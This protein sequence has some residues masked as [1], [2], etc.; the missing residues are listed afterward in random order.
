MAPTPVTVTGGGNTAADFAVGAGPPAFGIDA[1]GRAPAGDP[2]QFMNLGAQALGLNPG[3]ALDLVLAGDGLDGSFGDAN[4][5]ILNSNITIRQGSVF[6]DQFG[7]LRM[8]IDV[9]TPVA[10]IQ[11]ASIVLVKDGVFDAAGFQA[12]I[13]PGSIA[14]VGGTFTDVTATADAIPL[15]ANLNGFS[16]TFNGI[17]GAMFGVFDGPFDQANVQVPWGLDV[18]A[19]TVNVRVRWTDAGGTIESQPFAVP[20]APT[21]PG[22]FEF[23]FGQ[24]IVTNFSLA[25]DDV[26]QGSWA[27]PAGSVPGVVEQP[28]AIGGVITLWGNGLGPVMPAPPPTGAAPGVA[29][30]VEKTIRVL[31]GGVQAAVLGSVLH[32][33]SVGLN[34]INAIVPNGVTPGG[35]V[36]IVIE[37]DCGD[38]NVFRSRAG[39]T[40]AVRPRP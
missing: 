3:D 35:A 39:V 11:L 38:G 36:P 5:R 7:L 17:E 15:P 27:Q 8:T 22:I 29:L 19:G 2:N 24:A 32:G 6:F 12:L 30:F 14:A 23:P 1:I 10:G 4:V 31:V 18:S 9:A 20:A 21:S 26:I 13:S 37:V 25:G 28:A 33:A 34:Q 40:I 16:V